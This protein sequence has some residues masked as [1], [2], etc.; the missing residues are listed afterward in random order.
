MKT[1]SSDEPRLQDP[2][3]IVHK[4]QD[5]ITSFC[6]NQ[7]DESLRYKKRERMRGNK[8]VKYRAMM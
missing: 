6:I 4:E 7:V 8:K 5:I 3:K 2:M 1:G